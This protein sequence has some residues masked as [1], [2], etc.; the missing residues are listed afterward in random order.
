LE[1]RTSDVKRSFGNK[2]TWDKPF[3]EHYIRFANE[4]N[5]LIFDSGKNCIA[6]N[7]SVLQIDP[8]G[9]D[10]IYLDPPYIR[11]D[12]T[13]E[14][15]DYLKCYHFLEG[16]SN[17]TKWHEMIDFTTPNLRMRNPYNADEFSE[18]QI[19]ETIE[20][21]L[22]KFRKSIIVLS[23]KKGG[24]PSIDTLRKMMKKFKKEVYTTSMHYKY[25]LNNQNG[26]ALKN[27]EVLIIG[28]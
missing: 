10:L 24:T 23:Y 5:D 22:H 26:N 6:T 1:I 8:Y 27:R 25:A 9:I 13:N 4:A 20:E 14:S 7:R 15:S 11:K 12:S 17:Y 21:I 28:K 2:I 3:E 18:Y 19:F 16:L